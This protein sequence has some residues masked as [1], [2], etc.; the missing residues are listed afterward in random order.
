MA[1]VIVVCYAYSSLSAVAYGVCHA[2]TH[3]KHSIH[4]LQLDVD[5]SDL[6][7][8]D[9]GKD[10]APAGHHGNQALAFGSKYGT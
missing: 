1:L 7:D 6:F 9:L 4:P 3:G 5:E 10:A 8:F 2:G